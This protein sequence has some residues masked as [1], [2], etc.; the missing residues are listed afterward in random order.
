MSH[1]PWSSSRL[2]SHSLFSLTYTSVTGS[3]QD[4]GMS[5]HNNSIKLAL[6]KSLRIEPSISKPDIVISVG[7]GT[8]KDSISSRFTSFRHVLFDDCI[9]RLWRAYMSSFDDE[10]N[11]RDVVNNLD[12][13]N[14][15]DYKRL[16]VL[17]FINESDIDNTSRMSELQKSVR[18]NSQLRESCRKTLYA[19][20]IATFY[21][22]LDALSTNSLDKFQCFGTIR[23]RLP[24][25]VMIKLLGRIHSSRLT[26]ETSSKKLKYY[27]GMS[28]LC[29]LCKRYRKRV[30]FNVRDL[31][32]LI[33]IRVQSSERSLRKIS[34]FPQTVQWFVDRQA[35]N[36]PFGTA[37][38]GDLGHRSCR[39][40][41]KSGVCPSLK[42]RASDCEGGSS[43]RKKP[44]L[45][46]DR[47]LRS[48]CKGS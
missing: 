14:R 35:L 8:R 21:F 19:L 48:R 15:D 11:F 33:S 45:S 38:H 24:D 12:E 46:S 29:S 7:T 28:D 42:R 39:L 17:L 3:V 4:G 25:E 1:I 18:L 27:D 34:A 20:L 40:C 31:C 36:A 37:F 5:E 13:E 41:L 43:S 47:V 16:N 6:W 26:F 32:Q 30:E 23:C 9:P 2:S 22:E 44:Q 10:S